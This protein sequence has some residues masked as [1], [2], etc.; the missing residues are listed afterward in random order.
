MNLC[1]WTPM[2]SG[3]RV[4]LGL[5]RGAA[6]TVPLQCSSLH[7]APHLPRFPSRQLVVQPQGTHRC[8]NQK[9]SVQ[10]ASVGYG[11]WF[12]TLRLELHHPE[13]TEVA[14]SGVIS[15]GSTLKSHHTHQLWLLLSRYQLSFTISGGG[16]VCSSDSSQNKQ[17]KKWSEIFQ[18]GSV[19]APQPELSSHLYNPPS[20]LTAFTHQQKCSTNNQLTQFLRPVAGCSP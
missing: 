8:H 9:H 11:C 3:G 6:C 17:I 16:L 1:S 7:T 5:L 18:V 19:V 4:G 14:N 2:L 10:A 15:Q 12:A 13:R 20:A